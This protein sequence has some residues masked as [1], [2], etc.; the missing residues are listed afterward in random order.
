MSASVRSPHPNERLHTHLQCTS[1][2]MQVTAADVRARRADIL[3][4]LDLAI[5]DI[6]RNKAT[7]DRL[8]ELSQKYRKQSAGRAVDASNAPLPGRVYGRK[9][10][11]DPGPEPKKPAKEALDAPRTGSKIVEVSLGG[12]FGLLFTASYM[13]GS[14]PR[15]SPRWSG[16]ERRRCQA[17][18]AA[19]PGWSSRS[20]APE[21]DPALT[22][23]PCGISVSSIGQ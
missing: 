19:S 2:C 9:Q 11:D 22:W 14:H 21:T 18:F 3:A 20:P 12:L 23:S 8:S 1:F 17:A 13:D 4:R 10:P 5:A 15:Q 16:A 7:A 6:E